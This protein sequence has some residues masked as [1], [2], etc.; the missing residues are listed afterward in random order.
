MDIAGKTILIT[1]AGTGIGRA[2]AVALAKKGARLVLTGRRQAPLDETQRLANAEGGDATTLAGDVTDEQWREE[3]IDTMCVRNGGP[4][5]LINAAGVVSAGALEELQPE[6]I[7][8][9]IEVNLLAPILL[10]RALLP[11]LR[12]SPEAAIVDISSSIG[13][14]GMPFY[15][16]YAATKGGLARFDEA[17]RRE[18]SDAGIHVMTVYP[19]ATDTPMMDS[20]NDSGDYESPETVADALVA[21]LEENRVEV[22]RGGQAFADL[23]ARNHRDPQAADREV[24]QRKD[25]LRQ[26]AAEHRSM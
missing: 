3:A 8:R 2:T 17:L 10:I 22:I 1:G 16:A 25:S 24:A 7:R 9:Q 11:S 4:D 6:D 23:I 13:L 5:I 21:G 12:Q 15:T 19:S 14:V 26:R 20:A 18:L